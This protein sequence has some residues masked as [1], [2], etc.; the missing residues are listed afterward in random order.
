MPA[1]WRRSERG[2][3]SNRASGASVRGWTAILRETGGPVE[4]I[5]CGPDDRSVQAVNPTHTGMKLSPWDDVQ[6]GVRAGWARDA[7][8]SSVRHGQHRDPL[9][10]AIRVPTVRPVITA[11][12]E[13][14]GCFRR[15]P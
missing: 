2:A 13:R 14:T 12:G 6:Q 8:R 4:M 3:Q 7:P 5:G 10:V 11:P 9:E 1:A 15:D